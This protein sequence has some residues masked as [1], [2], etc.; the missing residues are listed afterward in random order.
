M[1]SP[2]D[3][4]HGDLLGRVLKAEADTV[5]PAGD[6]LTRIRERVERRRSRVRWL[7]PAAALGAAAA[8]TGIAFG[9]YTALSGK[10]ELRSGVANGGPSGGPTQPG[11]SLTTTQGPT[12]TPSGSTATVAGTPT[13]PVWPFTSYAQ[14]QLWQQQY[15]SG[16]Q[17]PWH[18]DAKYTA[19]AFVDSLKLPQQQ[20]KVLGLEPVAGGGAAVRIATT[21][22]GDGRPHE[23]AVVRLMR[24]GTGDQAPWE[25]TGVSTA[26]AR[27][28]S[29]A[30]GAA[31][32]SPL[33]VH[34]TLDGGVEEDVY[35]SVWD[36][37]A[38]LASGHAVVGG[39]AQ[40]AGLTF[41][42][43]QT[44]NGYVVVADIQGAS[45]RS[46]LT[47]LVV[48]PVRFT[49]A[50]TTPTSGQQY[51]PFF[52]AVSNDRITLYYSKLGGFGR[53]V[54]APHSGTVRSPQ[55][56]A[57]GR[58]VYFIR[59]DAGTG[60]L[61]R[62]PIQGGAEQPV[63]SGQGNVTAFAIGGNEAE[64]LAYVVSTNG[65]QDVHWQ[66]STNGHGGGF[67]ADATPPLVEQLAWAPDGRHFTAEVRTGTGWGLRTYDAAS[68]ASI[69]DGVAVPGTMRTEGPSYDA[70]GNLYY[71]R[72]ADAS[73]YELVQYDGTQVRH[74]STFTLPAGAGSPEA[75]TA[76]IT[77]DAYA[78]LVSTPSG[79]VYRVDNGTAHLLP[80]AATGATW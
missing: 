36:G 63:V 26:G 5:Q 8:L 34:Y 78:A 17:S 70:A 1:N 31:V 18:L 46:T 43:P 50:T 22:T 74:V 64:R 21:T 79:Q 10:D 48:T 32:G 9:T 76:D 65:A 72:T 55:L 56:S 39:G 69:D 3:D 2:Y 40:Q 53:Y 27:I 12:P 25:V 16:G 45:G 41:P 54:T 7:M 58:W 6:G 77:P 37:Q 19:Q 13:T 30:A 35:A 68:A 47:R 75:A 62:V 24:W 11:P 38:R 15:A 14:V 33:T 57:D 29:P 73:H 52:L 60:S 49:G 28:D 61:L 51:P 44:S 59:E 4:P 80:T 67:H 42:A 20:L 66:D 23:L 71:V